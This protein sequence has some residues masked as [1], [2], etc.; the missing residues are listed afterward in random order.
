MKRMIDLAHQAGVF[1]FHHNDGAIRKII[2]DMIEAGIDV[3]N[4]V[5]WRCAGMDREELKRDF[6]DELI[7]HGAMDNQHTLAFGS[8]QD[9]RDEVLENIRVLGAG[10][11][12]ILAP[13]HNLQ[14]IS[15][16]ENIVTMY[17]AGYEAGWS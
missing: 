7:F 1:V 4:P 15:P 14:A 2:P 5:Q 3:L 6:G 10:G 17:E 12:Y 13:C 9:V 8:Q 16:P 11:G